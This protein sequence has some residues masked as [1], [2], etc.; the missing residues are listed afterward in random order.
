M[1]ILLGAAM[2]NPTISKSAQPRTAKEFAASHPGG[3][4]TACAIAAQG[5]VP[6]APRQVF[7]PRERDGKLVAA[8]GACRDGVTGIKL[9]S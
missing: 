2:E 3:G 7:G 9:R 1:D 5:T 8:K 4:L 6:A